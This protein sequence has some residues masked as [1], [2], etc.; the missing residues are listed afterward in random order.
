MSKCEKCLNSM[1]A[2]AENDY[3]AAC[4]LPPRE[5]IECILAKKSHFV[6]IKRGE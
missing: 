1:I 5:F 6:C 2:L 4:M 3:F